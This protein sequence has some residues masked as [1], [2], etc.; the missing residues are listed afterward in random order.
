MIKSNTTDRADRVRELQ[1][2]LENQV[3]EL[4]TGEDW[5]KMLQTASRFH[6]YSANNV[7]LIMVQRPDATRVAGFQTWKSLGRY[8][9]KG[10]HGIRI[11]APCR[12][13]VETDDGDDRWIVR[14]FTTATVFDVS[15]TDGA[16]LPDAVPAVLLE[17]EAPAGLWDG[18]AK[19]VAEAGFM[20]ERCQPEQIG[21]ANGRT[22]FGARTVRVRSDVSDA[23]ATK[24]LAHELGHILCGHE[25]SLFGCRGRLEVEAESVAYVVCQAQ[26]MASDGYSLPYVA[27]WSGGDVAQVRQTAETVVRV[28]GGICEALEASQP[29][30]VAA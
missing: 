19:Q 7:M 25:V 8:V 4:V 20:L 21:G 24:T 27:G 3:A 5:A 6:R 15:Q 18:L 17:G 13:K 10:E 2:Q 26:G 9:R 16:D 14:G 11:L 1:A 29:V 30:L 23:Q 28:A 12:Y 22:D